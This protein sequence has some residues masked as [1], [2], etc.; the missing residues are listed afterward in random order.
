MDAGLVRIKF[1]LPVVVNVCIL[2]APLG[3]TV[4]PVA[5]AE[6]PPPPP[7]VNTVEIVETDVRR[8]PGFAC[9][10]TP[11]SIAMPEPGLIGE[12]TR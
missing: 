10:F 11:C 7:I 5:T 4:P 2:Y 1:V 8:N 12:Y 3:V 9:A 6:P